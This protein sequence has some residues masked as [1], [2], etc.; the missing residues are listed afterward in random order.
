[1]KLVMVHGNPYHPDYGGVEV[2][3][4]NLIKQLSNE[5]DIELIQLTFD[6]KKKILQ[7]ENNQIISLKRI[8]LGT[9]LFPLQLF[10]D[11]YRLRKMIEHIN[12]DL[13]HIQSTIP[14]F[15]LLGI[16]IAKI[17]PTILT[18]HGYLTEEYK[19]QS[20]LNKIFYRI[21][22]V[23]L[24]KK[25]LSKI[26][27]IIV[28]CPQIKEII[29]KVFNSTIYVIPNG[30][31][32]ERIQNIQPH[33]DIKKPSI[34][35]I[36]FLTKRKGVQDLIKAM[37][38]IRNE[39]PD[40]QLII[41]GDGPYLPKLKMITKNSKLEDF[42]HFKGFVSEDEKFQYLKATDIFVLP[43]YWESFPVVLPEALAC[44]KP[45]VTTNISG[46]PFAVSDGENGYL[47]KP[48]DVEGL[49]QK[50]ILLLKNEDLR[51]EMGHE[52]LKKS[53]EFQWDGI[54]QKTKKVYE[55]ILQ[56]SK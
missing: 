54:A 10:I 2:H 18:L 31:D 38:S 15:S 26:S 19:Y 35:F 25:A 27:T 32:H 8:P 52:S 3:T 12:P 43:T 30:I 24:E 41:I 29:Q 16:K 4:K 53:S 55:K 33:K 37:I 6:T 5:K 11:Q 34:L 47:L 44:G 39:I 50:I 42:V 9:I 17:N 13:V 7:N 48:G 36:G 28:V 45:I 22:C 21:F 23:P 20:T 46:N 56:T 49:A 1:M 51:K 40:A 14:T